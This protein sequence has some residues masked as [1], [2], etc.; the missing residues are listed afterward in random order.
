MHGQRR[1]VAPHL[2]TTSGQPRAIRGPAQTT[3]RTEDRKRKRGGRHRPWEKAPQIRTVQ[4]LC[5]HTHPQV[6]TCAAGR[7]REHA[8]AGIRRCEA[9]GPGSGTPAVGDFARRSQ[10]TVQP[11]VFRV[12]IAGMGG[13]SMI[14][15]ED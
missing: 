8:Q 5:L 9:G 7:A 11:D 10:G 12:R 3:V 15:I 13:R 6:G 14:V 4:G 1:V 2:T